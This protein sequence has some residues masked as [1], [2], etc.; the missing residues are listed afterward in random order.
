MDFAPEEQQCSRKKSRIPSP[1]GVQVRTIRSST[2]T[3][4]YQ[5]QQAPSA[6]NDKDVPKKPSILGRASRS[7]SASPRKTDPRIRV[8]DYPRGRDLRHARSK[9]LSHEDVRKARGWEHHAY[10]LPEEIYKPGDGPADF[11]QRVRLWYLEQDNIA[12]KEPQTLVELAVTTQRFERERKERE[13]K[14]AAIVA[15]V[16]VFKAG[17]WPPPSSIA[18]AVAPTQSED[19]IV[20]AEGEEQAGA[21]MGKAEHDAAVQARFKDSGIHMHSDDD[22]A[23]P[24]TGQAQDTVDID[25]D[26]TSDIDTNTNTDADAAAVTA[27][28]G[29]AQA[30]FKDSGIHVHS[31][32][33][34][35]IPD[36]AGQVEAN[37]DI[38]IDIDLTSDIT[39]NVDTDADTAA[40]IAQAEELVQANNVAPSTTGDDGVSDDDLDEGF[41]SDD[42]VDDF[43]GGESQNTE[44]AT[45]DS[46][47]VDDSAPDLLAPSSSDYKGKSKKAALVDG[48]EGYI[49]PP[50][51][52]YDGIL[53][54]LTPDME[55]NLGGDSTSNDAVSNATDD[56]DP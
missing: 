51:T 54:T 22:A 9:D 16:D 42:V 37:V 33:D 41:A 39:T 38:D 55:M 23:L 56:T 43:F 3:R 11:R 1:S 10:P 12:A 32:E 17:A 28:E 15:G 50:P 21:M 46:D 40:L 4:T 31:E 49:A 7:R 8:R 18:E 14:H 5:S 6:L 26:L 36:A 27:Q 29:L 48:D 25:I 53:G 44:D 52:E 30:V 19:D 20:M 47:I 35:T 34:A 13:A 24:D 2:S 45:E